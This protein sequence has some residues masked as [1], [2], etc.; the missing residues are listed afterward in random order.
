MCEQQVRDG[1]LSGLKECFI[2]VV[3]VKI[4]FRQRQ[5]WKKNTLICF[6]E[7]RFTSKEGEGVAITIKNITQGWSL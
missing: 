7:V 2:I 3:N 6:F 1:K 4:Y 5:S